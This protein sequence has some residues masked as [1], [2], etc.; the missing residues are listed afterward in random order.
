MSHS[1]FRPGASSLMPAPR[2]AA[3]RRAALCPA[4]T[5][6]PQPAPAAA[7]RRR[8]PREAPGCPRPLSRRLPPRLGGA[9]G[10]PCAP[11]SQAAGGGRPVLPRLLRSLRAPSPCP[12]GARLPALGLSL[13]PCCGFGPN[14]L[15]AAVA[16]HTA[17]PPPIRYRPPGRNTGAG[18]TT[19]ALLAC[20]PGW[21]QL[22]QPQALAACPTPHPGC[23]CKRQGFRPGPLQD[24]W[25]LSEFGTMTCCPRR[26]KPRFCTLGE[27]QHCPEGA[28]LA[29]T[30]SWSLVELKIQSDHGIFN[31]SQRE[32]GIGG[33]CCTDTHNGAS[34]ED[35][36]LLQPKGCRVSSWM[37]PLW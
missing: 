14:P 11:E 19:A 15:P 16:S 36:R 29:G 23:G 34:Y 28:G 22:C 20:G 24:F 21:C 3:S 4:Q 35:E 30:N 10:P 27:P 2:L 6:P 13:L 18:G 9:A 1:I 33:L 26:C 5:G 31:K 25:A 32:A 12:G 37:W 7:F 8:R 17:Y